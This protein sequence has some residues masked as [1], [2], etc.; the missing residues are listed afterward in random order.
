[1]FNTGDALPAG[2]QKWYRD[3]ASRAL[4]FPKGE[5][6]PEVSWSAGE[7]S[8]RVAGTPPNAE[9]R[10]TLRPSKFRLSE[11]SLHGPVATAL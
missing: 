11:K 3:L 2:F 5:M 4:Y 9:A 6:P 8:L 7:V 10:P 1:M